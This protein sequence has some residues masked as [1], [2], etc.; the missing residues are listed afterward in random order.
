[1][2]LLSTCESVDFF[3]CVVDQLPYF[4]SILW[5]FKNTKNGFFHLL[6]LKKHPLE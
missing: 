6:S 4:F 1:M 2:I 3:L 5:L